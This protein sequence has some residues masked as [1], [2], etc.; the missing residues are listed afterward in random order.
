MLFLK[1]VSLNVLSRSGQ[2]NT[3]LKKFTR[4]IV[5]A[6]IRTSY[7]KSWTAQLPGRIFL[8]MNDAV[9]FFKEIW[10][11]KHQFNHHWLSSRQCRSSRRNRKRN[12][13]GGILLLMKTRVAGTFQRFS[14]STFSNPDT[15][16]CDYYFSHFRVSLHFVARGFRN[17]TDSWQLQQRFSASWYGETELVAVNRAMT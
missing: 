8:W 2:G 10:W 4:W 16:V 14:T 12:G 9:G 5:K 7:R 3:V 13:L 1:T 11:H 15:V 6:A 17:L